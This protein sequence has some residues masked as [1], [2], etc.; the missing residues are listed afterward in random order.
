MS[1]AL[2]R[3]E[4]WVA[5]TLLGFAA[6]WLMLPFIGQPPEYHDFADKRSFLGIPNAADVASNLAF[7]LAGLYGA[8]GL[9]RG[10]RTLR[11]AVR[12][13]LAVFF[14][15]LFMT[16]LGSAYYHWRPVDSTLVLDRLPMTVAFAGVFGAI[17]GERVSERGGYALLVVML[18]AGIAS[19]LYWMRT[20]DLSAYAVVQFG[21]MAGLLALLIATRPGPEALPWWWLIGWYGVS[22]AL[23]LADI[24][25]WHASHGL[26]AGHL[27]KHVAAA[28]GGLIVAHAL[29]APARMRRVDPVPAELAADDRHR[30][31][32]SEA[33]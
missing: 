8:Y 29:R 16:A 9:W 17:A 25:I 14:A 22:K 12:A 26:V 24:D 13:S 18:M 31:T 32:T 15:G 3:S 28:I 21:G 10:A 27:L 30:A 19:V 2:S 20:D 33:R 1:S 4:R 11:P 6:L 7:A 5:V 23:E